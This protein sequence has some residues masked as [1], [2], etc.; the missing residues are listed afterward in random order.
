MLLW[1]RQGAGTLAATGPAIDLVPGRWILLPWGTPMTY[2]AHVKSPF[3]LAAVHWFPEHD[4]EAPVVFRVAHEDKS[5][6]SRL[7]SRR[8]APVARWNDQVL[9][10]DVAQAQGMIHLAEYIV[11]CFDGSRPSTGIMRTLADLLMAE[12]KRTVAQIHTVTGSS[13]LERARRYVSLHLDEQL[14][15]S[16]LAGVAGCSRATLARLFHHE[17]RTSPAAWIARMRVERARELLRSTAQ[18]VHEIAQSVGIA[19]P[20]YFS[21]FFSRQTGMSPRRYRATVRP[22]PL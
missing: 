19:D 5:P 11:T 14:D 3:L 12:V 16:R 8:D 6:L 4:P 1:C 22:E 17:M 10:G 20:F 7:A 18:P 15:L 9:Y 13:R 21:R 2:Q